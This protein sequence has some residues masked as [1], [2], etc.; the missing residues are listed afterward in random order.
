MGA[1]CSQAPGAR[2]QRPAERLRPRERTATAAQGAAHH[3]KQPA[4]GGGQYKVEYIFIYFKKN[5]KFILLSSRIHFV[6][7]TP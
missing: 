5:I 7:L 1:A 4:T 6:R 3:A 2:A